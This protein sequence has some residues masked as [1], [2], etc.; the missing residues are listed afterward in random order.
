MQTV[1]GMS[2]HDEVMTR[3]SEA[4]LRKILRLSVIHAYI[5]GGFVPVKLHVRDFSRRSSKWWHR[6]PFLSPAALILSVI[7]ISHIF[8]QP[9]H[10]F[11]LCFHSIPSLLRAV[12]FIGVTSC[13]SLIEPLQK[14]NPVLLGLDW[15]PEICQHSYPFFEI[16]HIRS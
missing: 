13:Q 6:R 2:E 12:A 4:C 15:N 7:H 16:G 1:S 8:S 11:Q 14:P 9:A 10:F 3:S 5:V